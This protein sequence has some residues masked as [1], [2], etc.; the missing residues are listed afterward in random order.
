MIW[1]AEEGEAGGEPRAEA[2][3]LRPVEVEAEAL[4]DEVPEEAELLLAELGVVVDVRVLHRGC[5]FL[6][7]PEAACRSSSC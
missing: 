1:E 3:T 2:P 4:V 6:R 5:S 7:A